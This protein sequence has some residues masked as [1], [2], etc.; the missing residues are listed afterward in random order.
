MASLSY[1]NKLDYLMQWEA[2]LT[3]IYDGNDKSCLIT[4]M[5]EPS[6]ANFIFLWALYLD[7]S[8]VH[9]QNQILFLEKLDK[10]FLETNP[11]ES[12][13]DRKTVSDEGDKIS[14]W[15]VDVNDIKMYLDYKTIDT[16]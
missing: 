5:F 14:E 6:T 16:L 4:S 15:D 12:I 11:Y 9:I 8:I 13:R 2:A 1:W 10:P 7:G 3:R